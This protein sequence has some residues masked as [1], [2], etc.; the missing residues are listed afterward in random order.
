[1]STTNTEADY[2]GVRLAAMN[3]LA[4]REHS[5]LELRQK[6]SRKFAVPALIDDVL[7]GLIA[8]RLQS[9]E[10]FAE[11]LIAVRRR[12]GK[13]PLWISRELREKGIQS[14]VIGSLLDE[15]DTDWLSLARDIRDRRFG[16][17]PV[18]D[19]RQRAKQVR[20]LSYRGF[21]HEQ[22]RCLLS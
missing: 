22:I 7:Q 8:D 21:S 17:N 9:D 16:S 13:G 10:R 2:A 3:L 18:S 4:M 6:L 1:M 15:S 11:A 20:F 19:P 12:Q 14:D 5:V